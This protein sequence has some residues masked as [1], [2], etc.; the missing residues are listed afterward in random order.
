MATNKFA[1]ILE[2]QTS[3]NPVAV[4][5]AIAIVPSKGF[6]IVDRDLRVIVIKEKSVTRALLTAEEENNLSSSLLH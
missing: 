3:L 4:V 5:A 6:S 2:I 1:T